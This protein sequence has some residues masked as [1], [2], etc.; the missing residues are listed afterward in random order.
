MTRVWN[1]D[2][3]FMSRSK[4]EYIQQSGVKESIFSVAAFHLLSLF[5]RGHRR[6][7]GILPLE[8][9]RTGSIFYV[10]L[11][12]HLS[13]PR[14]CC[15]PRL[16]WVMKCLKVSSNTV[17]VFTLVGGIW[18]DGWC[19]VLKFCR[20]YVPD[21][22][23]QEQDVFVMVVWGIRAECLFQKYWWRHSV[24]L[25]KTGAL[26]SPWL[27]Q[28]EEIRICFVSWTSNIFL[29]FL[30]VLCIKRDW[31]LGEMR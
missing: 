21:V 30:A 25:L 18:T 17:R 4:N 31:I 24:F 5:S 11:P 8:P 14:R 28:P 13:P 23:A 15:I 9:E 22:L 19:Y 27:L 2:A 6:T 20:F 10:P 7:G 1:K 3:K 16:A 29:E 26:F 12:S